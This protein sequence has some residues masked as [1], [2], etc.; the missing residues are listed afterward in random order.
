MFKHILK[1]MT[2]LSVLSLSA[3]VTV[4]NNTN[5]D[6]DAY[7]GFQGWKQI[8]DAIKVK[9]N[10][11]KNFSDKSGIGGIAVKNAAGTQQMNPVYTGPG[12]ETWSYDSITAT[13]TKDAN[14]RFQAV[15]E[16]KQTI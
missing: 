7:A 3:R 4:I 5:E 9:K 1:V 8:G 10:G 16:P 15:V 6:I 12:K 11:G 13:I 14:G 2:F